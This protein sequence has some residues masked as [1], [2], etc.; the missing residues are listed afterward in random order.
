MEAP[1]FL[2]LREKV[3]VRAAGKRVRMCAELLRW[4]CRGADALRWMHMHRCSQVIKDAHVWMV[5]V[6]IGGHDQCQRLQASFGETPGAEHSQ[7]LTVLMRSY[8][9][10]GTPDGH[11][12]YHQLKKALAK[13]H[14][15][16]MRAQY[17][18]A[19]I[20]SASAQAAGVALSVLDMHD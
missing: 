11:L 19:F 14:Q 18:E 6:R 7:M 2:S 4:T 13:E 15:L 10:A 20:L 5:W 17:D 8:S 16:I 1:S 9:T 12:W 3:Q